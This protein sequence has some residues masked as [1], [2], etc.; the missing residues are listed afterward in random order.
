MSLPLFSMGAI[1][2]VQLLALLWIKGLALSASH[3]A[4]TLGDA[5]YGKIGRVK[6]D[7]AQTQN[8]IIAS[9]S[10]AQLKKWADERGWKRVTPDKVDDVTKREP[11][12]LS[13]VDGSSTRIMTGT[14]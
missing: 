4:Q 2:L 13:S 12:T 9:T 3:R 11:L 7:I 1:L 10:P 5:T 8:K 6:E 14:S